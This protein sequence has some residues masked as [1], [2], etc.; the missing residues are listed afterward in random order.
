VSGKTGISSGALEGLLKRSSVNANP[1]VEDLAL[2]AANPTGRLS[3]GVSAGDA[4]PIGRIPHAARGA[5]VGALARGVEELL[6]RAALEEDALALLETEVSSEAADAETGVLVDPRAV[7]GSSEAVA[8]DRPL[9]GPAG[10]LLGAA[11]SEVLE[12]SLIAFVALASDEVEG[13]A[14]DLHSEAGSEAELLPGLAAGEGGV[15]LHALA[16]SDDLARDVAGEA[17]SGER[18]EVFAEGRDINAE[19]AESRWDLS[20]RADDLRADTVFDKETKNAARALLESAVELD[21]LHRNGDALQTLSVLS[22]RAVDNDRCAGTVSVQLE[23]VADAGEAFSGIG[24]ES[25]A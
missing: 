12:E 5:D 23:E 13:L 7:V 16:V 10:G 6:S 4:L 15:W 22:W 2:R 24:V 9:V 25:A 1:A 18:V 8:V 19:E 14:V 17:V 3:V 20:G 21:A 11:T